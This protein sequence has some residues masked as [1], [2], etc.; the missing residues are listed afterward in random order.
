MNDQIG[1]QDDRN[2]TITLVTKKKKTM[3]KSISDNRFNF[4]ADGV[5][6]VR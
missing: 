5:T 4:E 2:T 3:K 1:C 6:P